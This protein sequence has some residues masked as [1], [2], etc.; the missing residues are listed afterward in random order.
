MEI[1][2]KN[3]NVYYYHYKIFNGELS[4]VLIPIV[5]IL[6]FYINNYIKL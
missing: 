6:I 4:F 5:F 1:I 2:F 3:N